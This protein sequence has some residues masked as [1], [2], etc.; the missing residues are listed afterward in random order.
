MEEKMSKQTC[1]EI[2]LHIKKRYKLSHFK[3]KKKILD[4]FVA[5]TGYQRKYAIYLLNSKAEKTS[6]CQK[7]KI[8]RKKKYNE[9]AE[10]AL[11][12]IWQTANQICSKRFVPFI[13]DLL[14]SL[15]RFGHLALSTEVRNLLLT[16][17]PA[18]ADRLLDTVS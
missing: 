15:E 11:I 14:E 4:E 6:I 10:Q 18:T 7:D 1:K 16:I 17:S 9:E 12:K 2:L 3:D 13:P 5:T 8:P